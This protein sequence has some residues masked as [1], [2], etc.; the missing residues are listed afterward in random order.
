MASPAR[1]FCC[2][3][4]IWLLSVLSSIGFANAAQP[5]RSVIQIMAFIQ[6]PVWDAPWRFE[7]V[8]RAG[9]TGFVI[10]GKRIMTNAHVVSWARQVIV[11]RYQDPHPYNAVVL[12]NWTAAVAWVNRGIRLHG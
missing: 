1:A 12:N 4:A 9:G 5:E 11:R 10:K 8:H 2:C 6:Q 3:G 7:A